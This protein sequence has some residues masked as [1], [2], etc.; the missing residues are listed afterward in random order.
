MASLTVYD[1]G[2][3]NEEGHCTVLFVLDVQNLLMKRQLVSDMDWK[4]ILE[5]L[6]A[7]QQTTDVN[8][9]FAIKRISI[10]RTHHLQAKQIGRRNWNVAETRAPCR[11]AIPIAR[12][13]LADRIDKCAGLSCANL[14]CPRPSSA[15]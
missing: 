11:I 4:V 3:L 14:Q 10:F 2:L 6:F 1:H 8:A 12:I 7:M 5:T 9:E 15:T 13:G